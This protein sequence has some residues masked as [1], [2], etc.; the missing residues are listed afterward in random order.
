[1]RGMGGYMQVVILAGGLKSALSGEEGIPKPMAELGGKPCCNA[2][3]MLIK[4]VEWMKAYEKG[5]DIS[6]VLDKQIMEYTN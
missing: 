1:M 4:T 5:L 3:Q 2:E 6:S